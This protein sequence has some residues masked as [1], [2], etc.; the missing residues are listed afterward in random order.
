MRLRRY[1]LFVDMSAPRTD[2]LSTDGV[3]P[4]DTVNHPWMG[5]NWC[6]AIKSYLH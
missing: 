5:D 2:A 1:V 6:A 4:N 3:H